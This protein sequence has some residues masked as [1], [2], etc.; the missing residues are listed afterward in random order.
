MLICIVSI[1]LYS[2]YDPYIEVSDDAIAK[3]AQTQLYFT[4]FAS[5]VLRTGIKEEYNYN[6][7]IFDITLVAIQFIGPLFAAYYVYI[8]HSAGHHLRST[9]HDHAASKELPEKKK[10]IV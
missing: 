1:A 8:E 7:S 2:H 5:L 6:E 9:K 3:L 10:Y 4:L